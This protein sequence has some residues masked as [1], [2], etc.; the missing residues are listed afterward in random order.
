MTAVLG[1]AAVAHARDE[2]QRSRLADGGR[3]VR[4]RRAVANACLRVALETRPLGKRG[5]AELPV[6]GGG[7]RLYETHNPVVSD[8]VDRMVDG[9]LATAGNQ[10]DGV[11]PSQPPTVIDAASREIGE[12]EVSSL[13][14]RGLCF[15]LSGV[16]TGLR[17]PASG[18]AIGLYENRSARGAAT[19]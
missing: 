5:P 10:V 6:L 8:E 3:L 14:F 19:E 17:E 1:V 7:R 16:Q 4:H 13:A 2:R 15:R 11:M 18:R 12:E 9:T